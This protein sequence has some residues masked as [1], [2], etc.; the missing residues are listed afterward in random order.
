MLS[1]LDGIQ[2]LLIAMARFITSLRTSNLH[3]EYNIQTCFT[4]KYILEL[5]RLAK[6]ISI[7]VVVIVFKLVH[8]I[9]YAK[10]NTFHQHRNKRTRTILQFVTFQIVAVIT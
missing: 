6:L 4:Q 1:V 9:F 7:V 2:I 5:N 8:L 10:P 3:Y